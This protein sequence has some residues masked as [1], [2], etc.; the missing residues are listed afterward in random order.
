MSQ[1]VKNINISELILWT[2]NPR[3]PINKDATDQDIVDRA[4]LDTSSK[5]SLAKLAKKMG[6]YYD[7]S[8]LPTVVFH[9]GKPVVYDGNRR[10]ILGKIKHKIVKIPGSLKLEI[11]EIPIE[12][13]CN[14]CTKEIALQ[15]VLR[16]H[17][18]TG[19]WDPLEREIFLHKFM[20]KPKSPFLIIEEETGI[21]SQNPHLNQRYVRDEVFKKENLQKLG[22]STDNESLNSVYNE[23]E[24]SQIFSDISEK[25]RKKE[26][27]TRGPNRGKVIEALTPSTQKLIDQNQNRGFHPL[28]FQDRAAE[29]EKL[30]S[31]ENSNSEQTEPDKSSKK[32]PRQSSRTTKRPPELFGGKLYLNKSSASDLY[33]DIVDLYDF[34]TNKKEQ[35][36]SSFPSLI[37]MSLRLLC[38][39][40][41]KEK[42]YRFENYLT[43]N[44]AEAKKLLDQDTK[45]TISNQGVDD[46]KI[47]QL[48]HTGAHSY[49]SSN[50][51]DQTIAL[52]IIIG[53]I[54]TITYGK[55]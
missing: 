10:I 30:N 34:Y 51:I 8:E 13:P 26:I 53:K 45:T 23:D 36:S 18:E 17:G 39:T 24:S 21:I 16:K 46:K 3:D 22:F 35:L 47:V 15:N 28:N 14:V 50:N 40:A 33:R 42:G 29:Q 6:G 55:E 19:S 41:A 44:Y 1:Q 43:K 5:W 48:L 4:L 12:I 54:L 32:P 2:E 9:E 7:L 31:Q 38:E 49:K 52:S 27:T 11:P 25:I 37:R 20:G